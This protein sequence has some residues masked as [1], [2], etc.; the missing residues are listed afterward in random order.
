MHV[1]ALG[2]VTRETELSFE[3]QVRPRAERE[4]LGIS[5]DGVLS[6]AVRHKGRPIAVATAPPAVRAV[7]AT[8]A[9]SADIFRADAGKGA[10]AEATKIRA[11][12]P[13]QV[14]A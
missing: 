3:Y 12:L 14:S 8:S 7:P 4:A 11:Y 6:S 5:T 13:F 9:K 2:Q 1:S 10:D